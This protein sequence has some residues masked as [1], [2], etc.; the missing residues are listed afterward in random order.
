VTVA[1]AG[2]GYVFDLLAIFSVAER[3][4]RQSVKLAGQ[5]QQPDVV[6]TAYELMTLH[7][8][9]LGHWEAVL[10][11]GQQAAAAYHTTGDLRD[12]GWVTTWMALASAHRGDLSQALALAESLL[13]VGRDGG[14]Q[15]VRL[16]GVLM[17][18]YAELRLGR[19]P[20]ATTHA[21]QAIELAE[22]IP[23]YAGRVGAGVQL[24]QCY[25]RQGQLAAALDA[26]EASRRISLAYQVREPI[27]MA[28][29]R[30]G[31]A[32]AHLSAAEQSEIAERGDWLKQAGRACK[33]ALA[34]AN[35]V[36]GFRPE[37]LRWQGRYEWLK[38]KAARARQ[39]WQ[40]SLAEAEASEMQYELGLTH[41][42]L[43][44][45]LR[46]RAHLEKAEA[47]FTAINA[48]FDLVGARESLSQL[49]TAG[50]LHQDSTMI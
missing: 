38:G 16:L 15:Q 27:N 41:L 8:L 42:E 44:Q 45:R 48:E 21:Q 5:L 7:Q 3:F 19:L 37:A 22:S 30:N 49:R 32:E 50:E 18:G 9:Y 13:Q 6:S 34:Q 39:S 23:D 24:G 33:V 2:L 14:D 43:G 17:Q 1:T 35:A 11:L 46:E 4:H 36:R 47:I 12:W 31:L 10:T 26:L 28:K 40:R 25:L 20:E 29:L